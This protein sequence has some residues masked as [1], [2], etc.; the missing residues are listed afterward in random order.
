MAMVHDL[1]DFL[2]VGF[3]ER[4]AEDG[5]ILREYV[6]QTAIDAPEAGDESIA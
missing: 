2:R 5:E 3:R 6:D 1:G 4:A